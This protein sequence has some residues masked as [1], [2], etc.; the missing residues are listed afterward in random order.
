MMATT[1]IKF[2]FKVRLANGEYVTDDSLVPSVKNVHHAKS[3][4][5]FFD[6]KLTADAMG[7]GTQVIDEVTCEVQYTVPYGKR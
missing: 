6:A 5:N 3:Y 7:G 2:G 1:N 4:D